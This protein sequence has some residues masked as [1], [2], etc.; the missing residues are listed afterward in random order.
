[1]RSTYSCSTGSSGSQ[2]S[3]RAQSRT[4]VSRRSAAVN[5][6]ETRYGRAASAVMMLMIVVLMMEME[7]TVMMM[8][9]RMV[10]LVAVANMMMDGCDYKLPRCWRCMVMMVTNEHDGG[11]L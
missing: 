8:K 5:S 11:G 1:M 6:S 4:D 7:V 10:M 3:F 2:P 9:M